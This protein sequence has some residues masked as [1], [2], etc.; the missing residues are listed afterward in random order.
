MKKSKQSTDNPIPGRSCK[1]H[2]KSSKEKCYGTDERVGR[3]N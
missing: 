1:Y 2:K 3:I